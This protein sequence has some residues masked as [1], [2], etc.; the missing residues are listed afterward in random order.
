MTRLFVNTNIILDLLAAREPFVEEAQILFS[1]SETATVDL[2]TSAL[3]I[4]NTAYILNRQLDST[5][6][7]SLLRKF[8]TL[9]HIAPFSQTIIDLAIQD[10]AFTDL[11]DG[12]QYYTALNLPADAIIT[13]NLRDFRSSALPVLTARQWIDMHSLST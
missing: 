1:M 11:E 2:F 10:D 12:F 7:R 13:R 3:S 8:R 9:V 5:S 4:A 6:T